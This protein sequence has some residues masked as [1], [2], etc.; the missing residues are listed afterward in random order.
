MR[1]SSYANDEL[2]TGKKQENYKD[3]FLTTFS[4]LWPDELI[5]RIRVVT[6][7]FCL[8]GAKI[9]TVLTPLLLMALVDELNLLA[10]S[11]KSTNF[12]IWGVLGLALGY[13]LAR[14]SSVAFVQIRDFLFVNVAQNGL[15]KLSM[16]AFQHMHRLPLKFHLSRQ[17]GSIN[18]VIDRGVRGIEFLLRFVLF[19]IGPLIL[20]L[21]FVCILMIYKFDKIFLLII[22]V[23]ISAYVIFTVSVTNWRVRIRRKMNM[24]D[25]D[26]SQKT[27][28]SLLNY[29]TVKYFS[30]ENHEKEKY[31]KAL[32]SYEFFAIKTGKSLSMLNFGQALIVTLGLLILIVIST[33][34]VIEGSLT[35]GGLVGLNAIMLQLILPLNFLGTVYREIRQALVDMTDLFIL[36][37]EDVEEDEVE[38]DELT[39][40]EHGFI[41]DKVSFTYDGARKVVS[42]VSFSIPV[43]K[44]TA[45][46]GPSGSG[47]ST[48]GKLIFGFYKPSS[49]K[50]L[51]DGRTSTELKTNTVRTQLAVTPQD[52][53]LFNDTLKYNITY[54]SNQV[55]ADMLNHVI[56]RADLTDLV[57]S[58]PDGLFT[59]VGERGLKLSGGEK[60]RVAIARMLLKDCCINILDEATSSL[61]PK[62]EKRIVEN[63]LQK[64]ASKTLIIISHRLSSISS[65]EN[66]LVIENGRLTQEGK[67]DRLIREN[68]LYKEMWEKQKRHEVGDKRDKF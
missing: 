45:I 10:G 41:F 19:S 47:K 44:T 24:W 58:L 5:L 9:F 13:G 39:S 29:E 36:F 48:I 42:E 11:K 4:Y 8:V 50:I 28:D 35:V 18:K 20:E 56:E 65:A 16:H 32:K 33:K 34:Q 52:I 2:R 49:G 43:G 23:T 21:L 62:S 25:A 26:L 17:T 51:I 22:L 54:G 63:L 66:I 40:I 15:K 3:I 37:K 30:A 55:S 68:G 60:Q 57:S 6:S 1:S 59:Q 27:I 14:F 64:K 31:L 46:V 61:D 53:V 38:K 12:V 67:H 7:L